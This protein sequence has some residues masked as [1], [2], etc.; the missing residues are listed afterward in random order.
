[1]LLLLWL[2]AVSVQY[3]CCCCCCCCCVSKCC[4][5]WS[6]LCLLSLSLISGRQWPAVGRPALSPQL[7]LETLPACL[8][9]LSAQS[10]LRPLTDTSHWCGLAT[11]NTLPLTR[12]EMGGDWQCQVC[13]YIRIVGVQ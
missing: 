7:A 13:L 3:C 9:S 6:G 1:M 10:V 5:Q 8:A 12:G 2:V 4:W 11:V